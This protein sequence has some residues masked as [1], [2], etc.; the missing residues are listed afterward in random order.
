MWTR[1]ALNYM[2]VSGKTISESLSTL[3]SQ[4]GIKRLYASLP[5]AI[6]QVPTSRFFDASG[7][8]ARDR[9]S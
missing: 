9:E 2:Y 7:E 3:N 4:G 1:T 5:F 8:E 6:V